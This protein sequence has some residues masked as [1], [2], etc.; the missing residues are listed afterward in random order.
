MC[1]IK[2]IDLIKLAGLR[3]LELI[4]HS[5]VSSL[6]YP[7]ELGYYNLSGIN[8]NEVG[9]PAISLALVAIL[10]RDGG[11]VSFRGLLLLYEQNRLPVKNLQLC[12]YQI[13]KTGVE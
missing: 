1:L 12:S 13:L 2:R 9:L 8:W 3:L 5:C 10:L 7:I 4:I 6:I 11:Q